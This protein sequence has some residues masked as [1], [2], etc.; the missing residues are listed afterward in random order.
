M[1][2][3]SRPQR[4]ANDTSGEEC[5]RWVLDSPF[6]DPGHIEGGSMTHLPLI[7]P[8]WWAVP[9]LPLQNVSFQGPHSGSLRLRGAAGTPRR[10]VRVRDGSSRTLGRQGTDQTEM[11]P[12]PLDLQAGTANTS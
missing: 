4:W 6:A 2:E 10:P 8:R 5:V 3:T 12:G 7:K 11:L 9:T 1:G